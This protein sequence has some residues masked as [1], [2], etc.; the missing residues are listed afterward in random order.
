MYFINEFSQ[1]PSKSSILLFAVKVYLVHLCKRELRRIKNLLCAHWKVVFSFHSIKERQQSTL[2]KCISSLKRDCDLNLDRIHPNKA[3]KVD[4]VQGD[5]F[6][7]L[8]SYI[9]DKCEKVSFFKKMIDY[10]SYE[11]VHSFIHPRL[12]WLFI[13][14]NYHPSCS[15]MFHK[16]FEK[17]PIC[18]HVLQHSKKQVTR[19]SDENNDVKHAGLM[20]WWW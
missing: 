9:T 7:Y 1:F 16:C 4:L 13:S 15:P 12:E 14:I 18:L 5:L 11:C 20:S 17:K 6:Q 8:Q 2:K 19:K 10:A 3:N